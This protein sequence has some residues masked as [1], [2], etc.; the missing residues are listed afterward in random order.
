MKFEK[1]TFEQRNLE[2]IRDFDRNANYYCMVQ[3]NQFFSTDAYLAL[4]ARAQDK[5][6]KQSDPRKKV[7]L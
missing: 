7:D 6:N 5:L 1:K 3:M 2:M 4:M